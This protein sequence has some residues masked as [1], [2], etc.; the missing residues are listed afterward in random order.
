MICL[1][2]AGNLLAMSRCSRSDK[3]SPS[4]HFS[5]GKL[6]RRMATSSTTSRFVYPQRSTYVYST[7]HR[8]SQDS[9]PVHYLHVFSPSAVKDL[10]LPSIP[11]T[12]TQNPNRPA[13]PMIQRSLRYHLS[14]AQ[15]PHP[16]Q[17]RTCLRTAESIGTTTRGG[18]L[19]RGLITSG[20]K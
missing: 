11:N 12:K 18:V 9:Q 20:S 16:A 17:R 14:S 2:G 19:S 4:L 5:F 13:S 6:T 15:R 10:T 3:H 8:P 7:P 1:I